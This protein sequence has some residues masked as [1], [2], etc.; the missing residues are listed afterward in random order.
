M[1]GK[2]EQKSEDEVEQIINRFNLQDLSEEE[3]ETLK[4]MAQDRTLVTMSST[5]ITN[6]AF[7]KTLIYQ[8]W[9]IL[10]K[11]IEISKNKK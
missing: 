10:S 2:N 1:F 9:M 11:L 6:F 5:A 4:S 7:Q 3:K 8:N